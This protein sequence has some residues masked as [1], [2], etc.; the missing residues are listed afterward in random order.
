MRGADV[1]RVHQGNGVFRHV[2]QLVGRSHR[3]FQETQF[4]ELDRG[5]PLAAGHLAGLADVAVI[6]ADHPEAARG[7]LSAEIVIPVNHLGAEPHDQH[8]RLGIGVAK[9]LEADVD[10]VD[11]GDL[12]RLMVC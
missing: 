10:A 8:D 11:V 12:R 2:A 6:E 1:Q 5:Q 4:E 7:E 3:D 9:D